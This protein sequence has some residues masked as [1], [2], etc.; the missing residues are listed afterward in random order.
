MEKSFMITGSKKT[1]VMTVENDG[2]VQ[3]NTTTWNK[4]GFREWN[5]WSFWVTREYLEEKLIDLIQAFYGKPEW[6]AQHDWECKLA[7]SK[8]LFAQ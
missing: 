6:E 5:S 7:F 4:A 1:W 3:V 2:R 8:F